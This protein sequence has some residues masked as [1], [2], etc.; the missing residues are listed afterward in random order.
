MPTLLS[1]SVHHQLSSCSLRSYLEMF[2]PAYNC[3]G[4]EQRTYLSSRRH[5]VTSY[6]RPIIHDPLGYA[7]VIGH[8]IG[9]AR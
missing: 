8:L 2:E 4:I 1:Q 5:Y 3:E 7:S 9:Q 6:P